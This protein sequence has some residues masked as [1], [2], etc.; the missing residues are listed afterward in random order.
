MA[1]QFC[2]FE[3]KT[4][5]VTGA[6]SAEGIGF[7]CA[8]LLGE[9]GANIAL[10]A[11]GE[12]IYERQTELSNIG[13]NVQGYVADLMKRDATEAVIA[14]I[15]QEFGRI[16]VLVNNAGLAQVGQKDQSAFFADMDYEEWDT[17]LSRNLGITFNVTRN[18]LPHMKEAG[19][20]RIVNVSSV[21]GPLVSTSGDAAYGAAKAAVLGMSKAIAIEI[22]Q[23][24]ITINNVLPGWIKTAAQSKRGHIGGLNTPIGRSSTPLEVANAVVFLAS[25]EASYI[26]GQSLVVDGGNIIQEFKG[27]M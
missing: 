14:K 10:V 6:G 25:D 26:T 3:G 24:N 12:R 5:L 8:Q 18:V 27:V 20:G 4:A 9:L 11:T 1:K 13:I 19:G 16:D 22:G 17:T 21:T 2:N 23:D 15:L 7:K